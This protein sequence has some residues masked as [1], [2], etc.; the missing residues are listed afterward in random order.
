[1]DSATVAVD[2]VHSHATK[3]GLKYSLRYVS[4]TF[5]GIWSCYNQDCSEKP[6]ELSNCEVRKLLGS[7]SRVTYSTAARNG[8][9]KLPLDAMAGHFRRSCTFAAERP[10]EKRMPRSGRRTTGGIRGTRGRWVRGQGHALKAR[11]G[12]GSWAH[13]EMQRSVPRR[14]ASRPASCNLFL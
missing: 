13:A 5:R 7:V 14:L 12:R 2:R 4:S 6:C 11:E 9:A 1:M 3:S 8:Y 10:A